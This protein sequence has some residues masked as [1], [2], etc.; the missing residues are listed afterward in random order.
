MQGGQG[1]G[2]EEGVLHVRKGGKGEAGT[3]NIWDVKDG[4]GRQGVGGGVG[5]SAVRGRGHD[6]WLAPERAG[7]KFSWA[8]SLAGPL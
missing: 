7:A 1:V 4:T 6:R 2:R 5:A 3:L 8:D